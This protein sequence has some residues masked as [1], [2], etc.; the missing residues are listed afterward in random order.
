M[1]TKF[2]QNIYKHPLITPSDLN[3]IIKCHQK[4]HFKKAEFIL[5][6]GDQANDYYLIE[7]G[8]LRSFVYDYNGNEITTNFHCPNDIS[9]EYASLFQRQASNENIMAITDGLAWKI[10]Y[11]LFQ[12]LFHQNNGFREWG[13][14]W[15]SQQLFISTQRAIEMHTKSAK[16]RYIQL[17][18][19]NPQIVQNAPIKHIATYLGITDTSLSRIRKEIL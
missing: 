16:D 4:V 2:F 5:K 13:R 11:D 9:T 7:N 14:S 8:I 17:I 10:T 19:N 18:Q 1:N 6:I 15:L 12:K 3:V